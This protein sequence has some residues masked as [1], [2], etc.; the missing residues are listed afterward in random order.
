MKTIDPA[1][2]SLFTLSGCLTSGTLEAMAKGD[3][4]GEELLQVQN[5]LDECELCSDALDGV[6]DWLNKPSSVTGTISRRNKHV[7]EHYADRVKKI[8][9]RILGRVSVHKQVDAVRK[10][11]KMP[12]PYRWVALAASIILFL[13]IY[14][15]VRLRPVSD[16]EKLAVNKES[17]SVIKNDSTPVSVKETL[18]PATPSPGKVSPV[19]MEKNNKE[20]L[21]IIDNNADDEMFEDISVTSQNEL[22]DKE[23]VVQ[24]VPDQTSVSEEKT[25]VKNPDFGRQ[26]IGELK[27]QQNDKEEHEVA[28]LSVVEQMPEFPGGEKALLAFLS[29]NILYPASARESGIQGV[30]YVSFIVEATG[31]ISKPEVLRGIGGGCDEETLRV[32]KMMPD[33]IPG[34]H[35]GKAV[36]VKYNLPV[37]FKLTP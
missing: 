26:H 24:K 18:L 1:Y 29:K 14:Y 31:K 23:P 17:E 28:I 4:S 11:R 33:W 22:S 7:E 30:V 10:I 21:E 8:N 27:K 34:Q 35:R 9:H 16:K 3:I 6:K 2:K 15:M 37:S 13:G 25:A 36:S 20:A 5:H 19:K 12:N 32:I